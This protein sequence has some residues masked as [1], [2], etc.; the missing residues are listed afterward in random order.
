MTMSHLSSFPRRS[1]SAK[2]RP[3]RSLLNIRQQLLHNKS[4]SLNL[5]PSVSPHID[6]DL[7]LGRQTQ[8]AQQSHY[9]SPWTRDGGS[10]EGRGGPSIYLA[11]IGQSSPNTSLNST[12]TDLLRTDSGN[13]SLSTADSLSST[14]IESHCASLS[15]NYIEEYDVNFADEYSIKVNIYV[16]E[17]QAEVCIVG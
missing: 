2:H 5:D 11:S 1:G 13:S 12:H 17:T 3:T 14:S 6:F 4:H 16:P 8:T 7:E 9:G 15:H 10:A